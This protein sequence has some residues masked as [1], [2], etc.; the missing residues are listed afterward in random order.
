MFLN[1]TNEPCRDPERRNEPQ[2]KMRHLLAFALL[3]LA[4]FAASDQAVVVGVETYSP[5]V[6][7]STLKGCANDA[8][9]I[10]DVLKQDHFT[11]SLLLNEKATKAGILGELKRLETATDTKQRFVFYYA[12]HGRKSPRYALMPSDATYAGND[13]SPKELNDAIM[14][15]PAKSRTVILD[16]CFSGGMA[17]GE[18]SRGL[19]DDFV[20]RYF[21]GEAE[22]SLKFGIPPDKASKQDSNQSVEA[23]STGICYYTAALSSEQALEAVMPDG[24]RHGLFTY[25]L[26]N[27][28][29]EGKLWGEVHDG[30]KTTI[31]KQLANTGR[32]QNPTI[33]TQFKP[34]EVFNNAPNAAKKLPPKKTLLDIWNEDNPNPGKLS[35]VLKPDRDVLEAGRQISLDFEVGQDGYLIVVGQ[36]GDHYYQFWPSG[37]NV[38]DAAVKKGS[39]P[40][41]KGTDRL[42]FDEFG[43]DHVKAMLFASADAAQAVLNAIQA[44]SAEPKDLV[45]AR[46]VEESAV[47]SRLSVAVGDNL[48]GGARLKDLPGLYGKVLKQDTDLTRFI[49]SKMRIAGNGYEA[50]L[51]WLASVDASAPPSISDRSRFMVLL[52]LALQKGLLYD[53]RAFK[54]VRLPDSVKK[55]IKRPPAGDALM[56]LNRAILLALYPQEV[57]P[58][59]GR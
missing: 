53:D 22:R 14:R 12:G 23:G 17:A 40:F 28:L 29:K 56:A 3:A 5:L 49:V 48:V 6:A 20:G 54:G 1:M 51:S 38:T 59:D 25:A 34:D 26:L 27:N 36:V 30:V 21:D 35:L 11:I 16:S 55:G 58:D 18:M 9:S 42:F 24:T 45:L 2:V 41:P 32:T 52:N 57:N 43:N 19:T 15:I 39:V 7:A 4:D 10:A 44:T 47:T 13:I 33:S 31:G 50:G 46:S 8:N 37:A